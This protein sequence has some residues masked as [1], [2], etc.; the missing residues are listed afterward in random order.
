MMSMWEDISND[1]AYEMYCNKKYGIWTM[2]DGTEIAVSDMTTNHIKNCMRLVG[3]KNEW[4]KIFSDELNRRGVMMDSS[5]WE[6]FELITFTYYGK[7]YY[8][9]EDSGLV[10]SR[11]SHKYMTKEQ[12][13]D[14]FLNEIGDCE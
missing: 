12:A 7:T 14:E 10:Y 13:L 8:F 6:L 4:F 5:A 1:Y 2:R 11:V 9:P 3:E